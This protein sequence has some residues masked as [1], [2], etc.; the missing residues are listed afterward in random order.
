MVARPRKKTAD[1]VAP[2]MV[3]KPAKKRPNLANPTGRSTP[4]WIGKTPEDQVPHRVKW[5]VLL[6]YDRKC[7][8]TGRP[9]PPGSGFECDHIVTLISGGENCERNFTAGPQRK[10]IARKRPKTTRERQ[11]LMPPARNLSA[12]SA[13]RKKF[14]RLALLRRQQPVH[15]NSPC[16]LACCTRKSDLILLRQRKGCDRDKDRTSQP[17]KIF[18]TEI[19]GPVPNPR[20]LD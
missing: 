16:L 9:I 11:K 20:R 6:R 19:R 10:N 7:G 1:A 17:K 12:S 15:Q 13:R 8:L 14:S 4:E 18:R 5:R 3:A 2:N